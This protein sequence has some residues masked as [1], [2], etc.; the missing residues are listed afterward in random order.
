MIKNF[1][2]KSLLGR[3]L[4]IIVMPLIILQLVSAAIFYETHWAKVSRKL[5]YGLVGDITTLVELLRLES[6]DNSLKSIQ[7][8]ASQNMGLSLRL[9]K[10]QIL[11][12][13]DETG[14]NWDIEDTFVKVLRSSLQRPFNIKESAIEKHILVNIQ[15]S[16]GVLQVEFSRKRLFSSTTYVFV[17]WMV[18]TSMILFGLAT[19]FMRNQVKPIRRLAIAAEDFGKGR[20]TP[21]FK[22]EGAREVR[23]ASS[24]FI[25]M[26]DRIKRQ[27]S[28]RT[29]MLAGVSHD[30]RTPITRMKLQLELLKENKNTGDLVRD[31]SE[32]EHMLEG[33]LAFARG[34]GEE[35]PKE[36]DVVELVKQVIEDLKKNGA[37][38]GLS[39]EKEVLISL[40]PNLFRRCIANLIENADRYASAVFLELT[41]EAGFV[42]I[43]IDDNGPGISEK[44]RDQVFRPFFRIDDSRNLDTGGVG[45]GLT[46]ARDAIISHGGEIE[47]QD[48]PTGGLRVL[49]KLPF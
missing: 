20:D 45:L 7:A 39:S 36:V 13:V 42:K 16:Q 22:P 38:I 10:N 35:I 17:L 34:E 2:P 5:A 24:A 26:R 19:I 32:M 47:L 12:K 4:L 11:S 37:N 3:A 21:N 18:G 8:L 44:L 30:L 27:V 14:Q 25:A 31:L 40:R 49:I 23:Q 48:S 46:I 41:V 43:V 29:E 15:L 1:L 33:Y 9:K 6:A 28:R